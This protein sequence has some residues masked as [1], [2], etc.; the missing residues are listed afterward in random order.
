MI[1]GRCLRDPEERDIAGCTPGAGSL[2]SATIRHMTTRLDE[3]MNLVTAGRWD[4]RS[5]LGFWRD[6]WVLMWS[7]DER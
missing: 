4:D 5:G 7:D 3:F 6:L 2:D 1:E